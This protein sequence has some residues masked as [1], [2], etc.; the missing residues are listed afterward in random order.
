M[1]YKAGNTQ[2]KKTQVISFMIVSI[3]GSRMKVGGID[4]ELFKMIIN[5]YISEIMLIAC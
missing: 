5:L 4:H 2:C 1:N 3:L